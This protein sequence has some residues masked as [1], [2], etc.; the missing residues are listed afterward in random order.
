MNRLA[1]VKRWLACVVL[2]A[3]GC[4]TLPDFLVEAGRDAA[5]EALEKAVEEAVEEAV[6]GVVDDLWDL[7][8]VPHPLE[9]DSEGDRDADGEL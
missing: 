4:G 5:K 3:G 1:F 7:S 2:L 6:N 9:V 8:D